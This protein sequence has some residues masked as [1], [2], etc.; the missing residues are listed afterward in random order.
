MAKRTVVICTCTL[1]LLVGVFTFGKK[2]LS[3]RVGAN[4]TRPE[5]AS[6]AH[7]SVPDHVV[8]GVMFAKVVRLREKT[9]E[10]QTKGRVGLNG[11]FPLQREVTLTQG[12]ATVLEAIATSCQQLV[13][14]QDKKARQIVDAFRSQFVDGRVPPGERRRPRRN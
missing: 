11:Y 8:Y 13:R 6:E 4:V 14:Q 9:R 10:L 12:Q 2:T 3:E 5:H 1:L 7:P